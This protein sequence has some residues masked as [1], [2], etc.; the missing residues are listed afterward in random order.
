MENKNPNNPKTP[1]YD[2][3]SK[4]PNRLDFAKADYD[5]GTFADTASLE[6]I[7]DFKRFHDRI[8]GT[9]EE[10]QRNYNRNADGT[11]YDKSVYDLNFKEQA[12]YNLVD[13]AHR[14]RY[15]RD[16]FNMY[17]E[18]AKQDNTRVTMP[19][20]PKMTNG[21]SFIKNSI[22]KYNPGGP[23]VS[24]PFSDIYGEAVGSYSDTQGNTFDMGDMETSSGIS[25]EAALGALVS[26]GSNLIQ[27]SSLKKQFNKDLDDSQA[28]D[29]KAIKQLAGSQRT[30]QGKA[31]GEAGG[32]AIGAIFG[33][34]QLGGKVGEFIGGLASKIKGKKFKNKV[35]EKIEKETGEFLDFQ[36]GEETATALQNKREDE[37]SAQQKYLSSIG[38]AKYGGNFNGMVYGPRHE[39]G[40]VMMYKDGSPIAEVEGDEYVINND[41]LKDKP[42]SKKKFS[43]QGTP[44]QIASALNSINKYGVNTHPGGKVKQVS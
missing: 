25:N 23:L 21:G 13:Q 1:Y 30:A 16:Y 38:L 36:T 22:K 35:D 10:M 28:V 34:P 6:T 9:P 18:P 27:A 33:A 44:V 26:V 43:I 15:Q 14:E 7:K 39:E 24:S 42:E 20:V 11:I 19:I 2:S 41:I 29:N 3:V 12:E 40:G 4:R 32:T 17:P 37:F 31:I 8:S 5:I